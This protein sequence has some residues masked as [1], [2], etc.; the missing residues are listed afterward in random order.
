M[1]IKK[2]ATPASGVF[3]PV[4][5]AGV[6]TQ[7]SLCSFPAVPGV[8]A[9]TKQYLLCKTKPI[10]E[11]LKMNLTS[12]TTSTYEEKPP[13]EAPKN[14]AN[15]KPIR[16]KAKINLLVHVGGRQTSTKGQ[17]AHKT[18]PVYAKQ[19]QFAKSQNGPNRLW[20]QGLRKNPRSSRKKN[21]PNSNAQSRASFHRMVIKDFSNARVLEHLLLYER[22]I[23]HSLYRTMLELQ[24]LTL[25]RKLHLPEILQKEHD[26]KQERDPQKEAC[27]ASLLAHKIPPVMQNKANFPTPAN[28]P[29]LSSNKRLRTRTTPGGAKKQS[30]FK[31][32]QSQ[33]QTPHALKKPISASAAGK[34]AEQNI[35]PPEQYSYAP[36]RTFSPRRGQAVR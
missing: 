28:E 11:G 16:K 36:R 32:N 35:I 20:E 25:I 18:T 19:S 1:P 3:S 2:T 12:A 8:Y 13:L 27:Y 10:S 14:K 4:L 15:S 34:H 33:F 21:K 26:L 23:E 22:R 9:R 6:Q 24:R 29:N 7:G 31:A 5:W 17:C 30:Q